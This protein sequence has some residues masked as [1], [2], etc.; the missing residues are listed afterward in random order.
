MTP[1][2]S[3]VMAAYQAERHLAAALDSALAQTYPAIEII[4]VNDGSTDSTPRILESYQ[5]NFGITVLEQPNSGQSAALNHGL[6]RARGDYIKFFDADD[7]LAPESITIQVAALASHP[8]DRLAYGQWARFHTDPAEAVF[9]PR[10]GDLDAAPLDWLLA[11]WADAEPMYQCAL[12]LIPRTL[13]TRTRAWD[14]RLGLINDFE[15]FTRLAL[16]SGGIIHTPG[17]RLYYRSGLPGSL[18]QQTSRRALESAYLSCR[19]ATE[20]LL[21]HENSPRTRRAAAD[22]LMTFV[23]GYYPAAPDLMRSALTSINQLGGSNIRPGGGRVLKL[24]SRFLGWRFALRIRKL[25]R[26]LN[27]PPRSDHA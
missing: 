4:V 18:S 5:T 11:T 9:I 17:A 20:H 22:A 21:N 23:Q 12:W 16:A 8:S 19:L 2:V 25:V 1:L 14:E 6:T 10:P 15:F 3:I 24:I 27:C 7:I 13:I 26:R